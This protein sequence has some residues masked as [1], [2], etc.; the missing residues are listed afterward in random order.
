MKIRPR[1]SILIIGA[2]AL[3]TMAFAQLRI[4]CD[5]GDAFHEMQEFT[6][7]EKAQQSEPHPITHQ[8]SA[9]S[10]QAM[11]PHH[12]TSGHAPGGHSHKHADQHNVQA[13]P[14]Q[15]AS[16]PIALEH[17]KET[18]K[19][20]KEESSC[21]KS[22][23][24]SEWNRPTKAQAFVPFTYFVVLRLIIDS[25]NPATLVHDFKTTSLERCK[26]PPLFTHIPTTVLRI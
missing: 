3:L 2:C 10:T 8:K 26:P 20:Q 16:V 23:N 25:L 24:F 7:Q 13:S 4:L 12:H 14:S 19:D 17:N 11:A 6:Q 22:S 15:P 1:F 21:C 18:K 9:A 5:L